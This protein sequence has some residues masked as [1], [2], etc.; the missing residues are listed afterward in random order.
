MGRSANSKSHQLL[1]AGPWVVYPVGLNGG[2]E[3]VT[4]TLL[5]LLH[6]GASVITNEASILEDQYSFTS[7][8]GTRMYNF[9]SWWSAHH[10]SSQLTP[11]PSKAKSQY[12][13]R[14]RWPPNLGND[15]GIKPWIWTLPHRE[16]CYNGG[17]CIP[18][19]EVRGLT[20]AGQYIFSSKYGGDRDLSGGSPH[21]H[22]PTATAYSSGSASPSV[23]PMELWPN[24]NRATDNMLHL[25]RYT[26][27]RIERV[28]WE[29][30]VLLCQS[31]VNEAI[32]VAKAKVIHLQEVLDAKVGC[33][34]SVL[35]AKCNYRVAVK[36]AKKIRGNLLQKSEASYSKAMSEATALR[37]SQS[38]TLHREHM[39]L[40][41]E[42]E[43]QALGEESKSHHDFLSACQAALYHTPQPLREN[44]VTSYHVLLGWSPPS[45]PSVQPAKAPLV[46]EQLPTAGP[47]TPMPKWSPRPKRQL[48]SPGPQGST[49]I[50]GTTPKAAQGGP[51]SPKRQEAP[52]WLTSLKPSHVEAFLWDSD[53]L[54]EAR[55]HFFPSIHP[56]LLM[57]AL[58]TFLIS[59]RNWQRVPAYWEKLST[60]YNFHGLDLRS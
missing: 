55:L 3:P 8:G 9:A 59:S 23:D 21:Q 20:S 14:S 60:K 10:P 38:M 16:G 45:P 11:N 15:R 49:S 31:E 53:I 28:I 26:D 57:M 13:G 12:S 17:S 37:S 41:Q 32:S 5:E 29:L 40:I 47:P 50:D 44:L 2:D 36:E 52:T 24:T 46:A 19:L 54:I 1:S 34:R 4:T 30:G 58:M 22:S 35:E 18:T 56:T 43:E 42:L 48:P 6:S 33:S 51:S 7:P 25:K 27:L 39:R